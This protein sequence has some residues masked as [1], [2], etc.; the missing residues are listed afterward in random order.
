MA[1]GLSQ[2]GG[3]IGKLQKR[4]EEDNRF[5]TDTDQNRRHH[6]PHHIPRT[7]AQDRISLDRPGDR[8]H[9]ARHS[10]PL[11]LPPPPL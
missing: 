11:I 5:H 3:S 10:L 2:C 1:M 8:I 9:R 7:S 4:E 6:L